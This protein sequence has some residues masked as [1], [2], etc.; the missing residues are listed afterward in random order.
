MS[1]GVTRESG[2]QMMLLVVSSQVPLQQRCKFGAPLRP[3]RHGR[4][5]LEFQ[6]DSGNRQRGRTAQNLLRDL[7]VV[8]HHF[9]PGRVRHVHGRQ[10]KVDL[11]KNS[12]ASD[13]QPQSAL[14]RMRADPVQQQICARNC[15][16]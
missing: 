12:A 11:G 2:S 15:K 14:E 9:R 1:V 5:K 8:R 3:L 4:Q 13:G 6:Y 7:L 16:L 10:G